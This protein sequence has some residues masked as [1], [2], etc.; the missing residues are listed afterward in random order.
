MKAL[1]I[2]M[3][4]AANS[5]VN[6]SNTSSLSDSEYA[7]E[8]SR[9]A[10]NETIE[11][12]GASATFRNVKITRI[13]NRAGRRVCGEIQVNGYG[14]WRHFVV[15]LEGKGARVEPFTALRESLPQTFSQQCSKRG[16]AFAASA[17]PGQKGSPTDIVMCELAQVLNEASGYRGLFNFWRTV[18]CAPE[19]YEFKSVSIP[20]MKK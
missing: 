12:D 15:E 11:S 1:A 13:D 10:L 4:L 19:L 8:A 14:A 7:K 18:D 16:R 3:L 17:R 6:K 20:E 2:F 5:T 9:R